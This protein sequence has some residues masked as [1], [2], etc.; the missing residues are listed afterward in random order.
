MKSEFCFIGVLLLLG[1]TLANGQGTFLFDQQSSDESNIMEGGSGIGALAQ[2]FTPSLPAVGFIRLYLY[3][4]N[5]LDGLGDTIY[6]NLR[7]TSISGPV[8]GSTQPVVLG[9]NFVGA[10]DFLFSTPVVVTPNQTYFFQADILP[11]SGGFG[12]NVSTYNYVGGTAFF[13]GVPSPNNDLWFRE[14]IVVPEPSVWALLAVGC[15][16]LAWRKR[17]LW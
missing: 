1:S 17:K 15:V 7:S 4:G 11:G 10:A 14:G 6:V 12:L 2:S 5:L 8:L 16:V 9:P 3:D 13:Q